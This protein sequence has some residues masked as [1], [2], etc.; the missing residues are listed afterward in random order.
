MTITEP[1][2]NRRTPESVIVIATALACLPLLAI[3][4]FAAMA[5]VDDIDAVLF[6]YY[7]R[8]IVAGQQLYV[9]LWDNKPPGI[10]WVDAIGLWFSNGTYP[11]IVVVCSLATIG[12][13]V[14][15]FVIARRWYGLNV[16]AVG[17]VMA[18]L[19]I[20]L[21]YYRVG[22]NRPSTFYV[23]CELLVLLFY[24][25]SFDTPRSA[26]RNRF[27]AGA[28]AI[29]AMCFR[30]TAVSIPAAILVHQVYLLV[31]GGWSIAQVMRTIRPM[32]AGA[33]AALT[34]VLGLLRATS[35]LG[36]AWHAV[37][38]SN[39]G[40]V[41]ESKQ[42]RIVPEIYGWRE[43]ERVLGL[44]ALLAAA[45]VL[46]VIAVHVK[47]GR[48]RRESTTLQPAGAPPGVFALLV[49]W[50]PIAFYLALLGPHRAL[51]YY[52][53]ALPPLVMLATHGVWL[54]MRND[55][56]T[57]TPRFYVILAVLWFAHMALPVGATQL[58]S[59]MGAY[60]QR[61]DARYVDRYRQTVD[62]IL[63]HTA[64]GDRVH[65]MRYMPWVYWRADRPIAHR[66]ILETIIDQWNDRAQPYV[67][68]VIRDLKADPPAAIIASTSDMD[69]MDRGRPTLPVTY[70]DLGAWIRENYRLVEPRGADV[71][72]RIP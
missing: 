9:D 33:F 44:P 13:C 38:V 22:S 43:H 63:E 39:L 59:A 64:P 35:D 67:D 37:V 68:E 23:L 8:R 65:S 55:G 21:Y 14:S 12:S 52:G 58:R 40:Y 19:Y 70:R 30:Q 7:G 46:Y 56:G 34:V 29:G 2:L 42:S 26:S 18:A 25:R 69:D 50:L 51:H 10:F 20:N 32:A 48:S 3:A 17:T 53:V 54:L 4:Q 28:C 31:A 61:F 41:T 45:T 6:A 60:N 5:R 11:G 1:S 62:A 57:R 71:W 16:A 36:A 47:R 15:F 72:I 27:I 24:A 49:A 66:Y